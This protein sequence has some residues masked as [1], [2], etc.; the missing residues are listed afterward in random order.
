M[1]KAE[2][3]KD[4]K[5]AKAAREEIARIAEIERRSTLRV[6]EQLEE[7]TGLESRMTILGHLQR[8]GTPSAGDRLLASRLGVRAA[9]LVNEGTF[10]V[11][12]AARG[13][14]GGGGAAGEGGGESQG[15]SA[16]PP[17]G[18]DG[19]AVERLLWGLATRKVLGVRR[20]GEKG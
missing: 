16:G 1:T 5:E 10:G 12:V 13:S 20:Y 8:G 2:D 18:A 15:G 9:E 4:K 3:K 17:L 14:G 7:L 6:T 11:M 19:A